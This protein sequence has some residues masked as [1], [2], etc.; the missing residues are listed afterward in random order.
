MIYKI[1]PVFKDYIWGGTRLRDEF[2][3]NTDITPLAESWELSCHKDGLSLLEGEEKT[4]A[5]HISENPSVLGTSIR[6][7]ELPIL[8]KLID[9]AD[10]LSVQVHPDDEFAKKYENQNGKTEM[11]YIVDALPGAKIIYGLKKSSSKDELSAAIAEGRA[12][13]L[14]NSVPAQKG[15]VFFVEAGTIHAI[16]KGCLIAEIQQN[17]NVTYRLYDYNRVGKDGKPRE[18]HIEKG[19]SCANTE[20]VN[21]R[22]V[23]MLP[24]GSRLLGECPFFRVTEHR[25]DGEKTFAADG[26]S[27]HALLFVEGSGE[28]RWNEKSLDV[29][30]GGCVF[31]DAGTG[32]YTIFGKC[33]VL[34]TVQP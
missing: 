17:S 32:A 14:L 27:Y 8:I 4:L 2:G 9:A 18:L 6:N 7:G 10:N 21:N 26:S 3:K 24:D 5:S 19:V 23:A 1:S 29:P 13:E 33:T 11:W 20:P 34:L 22:P 31:I 16:G 28:I 15:D 12:E 30:K 25:I